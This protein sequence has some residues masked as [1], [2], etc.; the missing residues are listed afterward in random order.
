MFN[1]NL[2][3]LILIALL[4][5]ENQKPNFSGNWKPDETKSSTQKR[6][7][8]TADAAKATAPPPP[9]SD[10]RLPSEQIEHNE[11]VLRIVAISAK[12]ERLNEVTMRTDGKEHIIKIG[13]GAM[14][15]RSK[16]HWEGDTLVTQWHI[17]RD[18]K[19]VIEG[20]DQRSLSEG[21]KV[22]TI[23]RHTEDDKSES[24]SVIVYRK[25]P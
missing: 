18:G 1:I 14:I 17:E 11:P 3:T 8:T 15:H 6:L 23:N 22:L 25:Q 20:V 9:P 2:V 24:D 10:A 12:G 7:K 5:V 19:I 16:S 21:G 13:A 4:G